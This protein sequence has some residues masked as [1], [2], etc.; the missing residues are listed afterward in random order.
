MEENSLLEFSVEGPAEIIG[1]ING[2]MKSPEMTVGTSRSLYNGT[3]TVILRSTPEAGNVTLKVTPK[4]NI[5]GNIK[6]TTIKLNT[7]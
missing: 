6:G 3:A 1:V 2:D 5:K 7:L 4:G